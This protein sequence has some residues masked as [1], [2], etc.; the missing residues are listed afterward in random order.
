M[1]EETEKRRQNLGID[2]L[3]FF[4]FYS[5]SEI[6]DLIKLLKLLIFLIDDMSSFN[7]DS[8]LIFYKL[9]LTVHQTRVL[10]FPWELVKSLCSLPSR[11]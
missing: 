10:L 11:C 3:P 2:S 7:N 8:D 6:T 9:L 5:V 4:N 1:V